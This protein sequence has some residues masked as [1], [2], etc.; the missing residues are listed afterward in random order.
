MLTKDD[1]SQIQEMTSNS[2]GEF[3]DKVLEP[4]FSGEFGRIDKRL[5]ENDEDHDDMFR[6]LD[7]NQDQHDQMFVKLDSIEKK[8]DGHERKIK[9]LEK[10]LQTS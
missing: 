3:F 4:Y 2:L 7:Q 1:L 10:T 9:K 5:Q 8:V 6:K